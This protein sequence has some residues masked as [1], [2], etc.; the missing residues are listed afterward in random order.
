MDGA[1]KLEQIDSNGDYANIQCQQCDRFFSSERSLRCHVKVHN[2]KVLKCC[3]CEQMF[4]RTDTL[5]LHAL[6][7]ISKGTLPCRAEGCEVIVNS[8][9]DGEHHANINHHNGALPMLKCRDC[10]ETLTSFRKMLYHYTFKHG[11]LKEYADEMTAKQKDFLRVKKN[12]SRKEKR[13]G[14]GPGDNVKVELC[15]EEKNDNNITRE[16]SENKNENESE[17]LGEGNNHI[18]ELLQ[19]ALNGSTETN[20]EMIGKISDIIAELFPLAGGE[21]YQCLHCMMGFT[22]A[23]LWMTHLGYHDAQTPFKCSG[24]KRQFENRQT[25]VLHLTYFAHG[26]DLDIDK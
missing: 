14:E 11:E 20:T 2:D 9:S 1:P 24:C 3:F 16:T 8:M 22:D 7:H 26:G 19:A 6:D 23:I 17:E 12:Q 15:L 13:L 10:P 5:F 25:F 4:N 18:L 21:Q